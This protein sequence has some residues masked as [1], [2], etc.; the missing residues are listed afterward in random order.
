[1]AADTLG[2]MIN[3]WSQIMNVLSGGTGKILDP[4]KKGALKKTNKELKEMF[5]KE[6]KDVLG[7]RLKKLEKEIADDKKNGKDWAKKAVQMAALQAVAK[8]LGEA[9]FDTAS[10]C[11]TVAL[12]AT[13]CGQ[14]DGRI[15]YSPWNGRENAKCQSKTDPK[16]GNVTVTYKTWDWRFA[17]GFKEWEG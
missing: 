13:K 11:N 8:D 10:V 15:V 3:A 12:C 4:L 1:M 17:A 14:A 7:N 16:T 6:M 5:A 9:A 2:N